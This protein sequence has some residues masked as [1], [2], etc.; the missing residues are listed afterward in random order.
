MASEK[1]LLSGEFNGHV[2]SDMGCFGEVH[3]GLG[4]G[5]INNGEI[6]CWI[7]QLV[8]GCL[9]IKALNSPFWG[10][11]NYWVVPRLTQP[12][13]LPRSIK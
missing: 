9:V 12:F 8:N 1:V 3:G 2:G 11:Q 4:I 13:I 10:V 6:N 5:Q 7:W